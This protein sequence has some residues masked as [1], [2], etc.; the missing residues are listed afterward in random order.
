MLAEENEGMIKTEKKDRRN[1]MGRGGVCLGSG[2][3]KSMF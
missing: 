1:W 2:N 3:T